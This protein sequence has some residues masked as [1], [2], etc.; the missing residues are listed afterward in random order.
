MVARSGLE[1]E[2]SDNETEML[3]LHHP[4]I[5][6]LRSVSHT[7]VDYWNFCFSNSA[8]RVNRSHFNQ[9]KSG[10]FKRYPKFNQIH[11]ILLPLFKPT[12]LSIVGNII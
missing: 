7:F 6:T 8:L 12:A 3:P 5:V 9:R 1:P 2:S 4:A 10:I 11:G